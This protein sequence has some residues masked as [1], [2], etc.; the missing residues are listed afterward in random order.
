[1][2]MSFAGIPH[3]SST[4]P[5]PPGL[6]TLISISFDPTTSSPD[7][8]HPVGE[9]LRT[10]HAHQLEHLVGDLDRL[11]F[12]SDVHVGPQVRA[13][14]G[15]P[16][17]ADVPVPLH[18]FAVEHED[19]H[20]A[21]V[22]ARQILLRHDVAVARDRV[23]DLVEV[24]G[25][26]VGHEEDAATARALE[27]LE[28]G[29]TTDV[30]DELRDRVPVAGDERPRPHGL[31]E[32]LEV[33]LV[34]RVRE[35]ERIVRDEHAACRRELAEQHARGD[36]PRPIDDVLGGIVAHH[37]DVEVVDLESRLGGVVALDVGE[38]R[39][40]VAVATGAVRARAATQPVGSWEKSPTPSS[41]A[42]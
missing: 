33:R 35:T 27:R 17:R 8:E 13:G 42:S 37:E 28:H 25:L 6:N 12:A 16:E 10:D 26:L 7:E 31:G 3:S 18:R 34:Q 38:E 36:R 5:S 30:G 15:A 39:G 11:R 32:V 1:M 2:T 23:D 9:K 4:T 29:S 19:A 41:H 22:R 14:V 24:R 20:V 21:V 40:A